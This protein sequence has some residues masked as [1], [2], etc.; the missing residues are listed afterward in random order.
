M[1]KKKGEEA[2]DRLEKHVTP[3]AVTRTL[4]SSGLEGA[5][6]EDQGK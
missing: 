1:F 6:G 3:S 2:A 4:D 5:E